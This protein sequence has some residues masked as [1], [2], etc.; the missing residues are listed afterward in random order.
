MANILLLGAGFSKNWGAPVAHEFFTQ[1]IAD[2]EIQQ[3]PQIQ[4]LLWSNWTNFEEALDQLQRNYRQNMQANR[5]PLQLFIRAML[6]VFDRMTT[7]FKRQEF[8]LSE[9]KLV[10]DRSRRVVEFLAK[11]DAV[12]TLN[13][14]LLLE[15]HYFDE[16]HNTSTGRRWGGSNLP[17][18]VAVG[19][20][21]SN[22]PWSSRVWKPEGNIS[23]EKNVQ[24]YFKLHGSRNWRTADDAEDIIIMGGGKTLQSGSSRCY[25]AIKRLSLDTS[26]NRVR[27][28]P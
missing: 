3:N 10:P 27:E 9:Q 1:L 28:L 7:I 8:D 23:V 25:C 6:R 24:P 14:D 20:M 2:E 11:F 15:Y 4:Q 13:Q 12:F 26:N 22:R 18:M 16:H 17:G 19:Q 5:E 21:E